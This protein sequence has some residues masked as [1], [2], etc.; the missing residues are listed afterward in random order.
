VAAAGEDLLM[1]GAL[2]VAS[3]AMLMA[4]C[5]SDPSSFD[6][7]G[8]E[9]KDAGSSRIEWRLEQET[10]EPRF[11]STGEGSIDYAKDRGE[12]SFVLE[13][14]SKRKTSRTEM[15]AIFIGRDSYMAVPY[16]GKT[17]WQKLSDYEASGP[18]RF[19]PGPGGPRPDEALDL[20]VKSS[21]NVE[22]VGN[23]EIRGVSADHYRAH[24]DQKVMGDEAD[25][26][27]PKG[28]VIDAWIDGDGLLRRIRIPYG[29]T[30][31]P[32][33]VIDLY[34][35]GVPVDVKAPSA[36]EV[37][38][39]EEMSRLMEKECQSSDADKN[40]WCLVFGSELVSEGSVEISP[41]ETMPRRVTDSK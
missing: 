33:E 24:V 8:Q 3:T 15:R 19:A 29:G 26:F 2:L 5:G 14:S 20:L 12:A 9:L 31:G 1:R 36:D 7:S 17:L 16:R 41:T 4:G 18:Y 32:V 40:A 37:V 30:E 35:F 25:M 13:W 21:K 11:S 38:S 28:L 23:D 34:D 10:T 39:E 6:N 22:K 27:G